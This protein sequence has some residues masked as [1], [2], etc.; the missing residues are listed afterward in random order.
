MSEQDVQNAYEVEMDNVVEGTRCPRCIEFDF[1]SC[2]G[3][4]SFYT[5]Q[6]VR[7]TTRDEVLAD[8]TRWYPSQTID[9]ETIGRNMRQPRWVEAEIE[10]CDRWRRHC[11]WCDESYLLPTDA[12]ST[13]DSGFY[14]VSTSYSNSEQLCRSCADD[15][16]VCDRCESLISSDEVNTINHDYIWCMECT[17]TNA[18]WC[19]ECEM[20]FRTG[21]HECPYDEERSPQRIHDYSWRPAPQ[22]R[23]IVEQDGDLGSTDLRRTMFMGFELEVEFQ[24]S[25]RESV[26][27]VCDAALGD[28]AYYK[29][30]GSLSDGFEIVT[31]P[32]T[33]AA[34]KAL[35]DW[36][37]TKTI[38]DMGCRSWQAKT[39][40][41]HVHVSRSAFIGQRHLA[42]FQFL[43]LN[44]KT[45]MTA[46]AGRDSDRW[47]TFEGVKRNV[48]PEMKGKAW[49]ARYEAINV[50]N[51]NTIELRMFRGTLNHLRVLAILELVDAAFHYTRTMTAKQYAEGASEFDRFANWFMQREEYAH[52]TKF[53]TDNLTNSISR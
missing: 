33:L 20:Y 25:D 46:I 28:K 22:F 21:R 50:T 6:N 15:A 32:M 38:S 5:I 16:Y 3:D 29:H 30:D 40:G 10:V 11:S 26:L 12:D 17:D 1:S 52:L 44:N 2:S 7:N 13:Y 42:L 24:G 34:H 23:W 53:T 39:C 43:F 27:D 48:I 35:I 47:A 18:D 49:R 14:G 37:F 51:E 9:E 36:G 45:V 31:H 19:H 41:L 8:F 4:L